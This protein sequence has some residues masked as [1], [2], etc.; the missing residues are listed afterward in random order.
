MRNPGIPVTPQMIFENIWNEEPGAEE[1]TV[2]TCVS[3]LRRKLVA[4]CSG[5]TT[6]TNR[7]GKVA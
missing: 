6:S 1:S 5:I 7:F 4:V 2:W 3:Y